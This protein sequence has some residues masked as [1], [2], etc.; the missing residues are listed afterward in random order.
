MITLYL[1]LLFKFI[2]SERL[3]NSLRGPDVVL[4]P[5]FINI[6][7]ILCYNFI[8]FVILLYSFSVIPFAQYEEYIICLISFSKFSDVLPTCTSA[9][10]NLLIICLVVNIFSPS[11]NFTSY[12]GSDSEKEFKF[13]KKSI[14]FFLNQKYCQHFALH[15]F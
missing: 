9:V 3:S 11:P 5:E 12:L 10:G 15:T 13:S 8:E 6:L 1:S 14:I 4:F 7:S 2:L